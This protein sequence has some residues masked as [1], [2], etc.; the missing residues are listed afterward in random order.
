MFP[1][2]KFLITVLY[3]L[4]RGFYRELQKA[5]VDMKWNYLYQIICVKHTEP[6]YVVTMQEYDH[7]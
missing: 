7:Y 1:V 4:K 2:S 6:N 5:I 3:Y